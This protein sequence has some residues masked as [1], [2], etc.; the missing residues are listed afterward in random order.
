MK[1]SVIT[2]TMILFLIACN[3]EKNKEKGPSGASL[4]CDSLFSKDHDIRAFDFGMAR[5][6]FDLGDDSTILE[7]EKDH[8]VQSITTNSDSVYAECS[9]RF[10][11]DLFQSGEILIFS[12]ND[13]IHKM[14]ND[15]VVKSMNNKYGKALESRGFYTWKTRSRKGYLMEIFLG[16]LSYELGNTLQIQIFADLVEKPMLAKLNL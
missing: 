5:E 7:N 8:I 10:E 6:E 13:S 11:D 4:I 15:S 12:P 1:F 9:Y 14:V 3:S 16:D 2:A